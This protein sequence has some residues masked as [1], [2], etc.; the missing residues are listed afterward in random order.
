MFNDA[1]EHLHGKFRRRLNFAKSPF[2]PLSSLGTVAI[3][4]LVLILL[5]CNRGVLQNFD[6]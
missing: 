3:F 2:F 6:R 5:H 1:E 4:I